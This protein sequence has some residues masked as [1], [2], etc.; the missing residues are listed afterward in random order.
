MADARF[1]KASGPF[2]LAR[3]AE[4][5]VAT[6]APGGDL[7]RIFKDVATLEAAGA[8]DVSFL[9]N[10]KYLSAFAA[11]RA[12]ACI[13]RP[14]MADRAPRGMALLLTPTPYKA[15]ARVARAF[16][17]EPAAR[18]GIDSS[19][20]VDPT[21]K[22]AADAWIG[23]RATIGANAEIGAG[24]QIGPSAV[25]GEGVVLGSGTKVG[26]NASVTHALVGERVTIYPGARIGQDGFGFAPDPAGHLKVPQLGRVLIGDDCEIGANTCID[27][28]AI[29]DTVI[30]PGCMIDNL[31]QIGHNVRLGRGCVIVAQ[32][33]ISGSTRLDDFVVVGGQGG[34]AGH[35]HIGQG[36][37]IAAQSGVHRDIAPGEIVGGYPAV[38]IGEWRRQAAALKRLVKR[39][40]D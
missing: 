29:S 6:I 23:P 3:L 20:S 40:G 25:I 24:C 17:P 22:V 7:G 4:I 36:A 8:S 2:T 16:Y 12:G 10:R 13:V 37:Q 9:E 18:S 14:D 32:V 33:G 34:L 30:G 39:K 15:Y 21:A 31:V 38:P 5:A 11:S 28:G 1:Y 35:I 26:A 27:R 19:A